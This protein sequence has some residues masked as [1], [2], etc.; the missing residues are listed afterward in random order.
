[1]SEE[2]LVKNVDAGYET[3]KV[4]WDVSLTVKKKEAVALI[5]PNGHGKSTL[6]KT[7]CGLL[8]PTK[9]EIYF[10]GVKI[11]ELPYYKICELGLIYVPEAG[12]LFPNMTVQENLLLGAYMKKVWDTREQNLKNVF[13]L[14]PQLKGRKNQK[15]LTLSGGERKMVTIGRALMSQPKMLLIDELSL[16]L[17]PTTTQKV[18]EKLETI[19]NMGIT[20]L[21]VDQNI[22]NLT[23]C[24]RAYLME[25][26]KIV[27]EG[28]IDE[29]LMK[30][31]GVF[32][33]ED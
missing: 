5:G 32:L 12:N 16:G 3:L 6:L 1:M 8:K 24:N 10:N 7:I 31:K 11:S 9:G 21:L 27:A 14:F 2:L 4:L 20:I 18:I 22:N 15:V 23:I 17:A 29:V 13:D 19:K 25:N 28:G 33:G 26:G 30:S